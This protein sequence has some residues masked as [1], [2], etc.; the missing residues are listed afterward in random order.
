M[1]KPRNRKRS[2]DFHGKNAPGSDGPRLCATGIML[3]WGV[4]MT[5]RER[6]LN[7]CR[8]Q[9]VD[10]PPVWLMRQAGRALPEYRALRERYSFLDLVRTPELAAEVTLQPIRRFGFDAAIIFSDILVI[11]E[12]LGQAYRFRDGGGIDMAFPIRSAQD[13]PKLSWEGVA[14]RAQYV[15]DALRSTQNQLAGQTALIGFSGSPWTLANFMVEGGSAKP[16]TQALHWWREDRRTFEGFLEKLAQAV[17]EYLKGQIAAG[18]EA[19]QIFDSLSEATPIAEY[20]AISARWI[21]TIIAEL[22]GR[23]PV[24]VF[25]RGPRWPSLTASGAQVLSVDWMVSLPELRRA[26]P[27]TLAI[28]GNLNPDVLNGTLEGVTTETT[29]ILME[30]K[31]RNGFIF[32]LGHGLPPTATIENVARLVEIIRNSHG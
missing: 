31:G 7:A 28:Q 19:V 29:R 22:A 24:M 20:E 6:F 30:M 16:F 8:C 25:S 15:F 26:L 3:R 17:A 32:N 13:L 23:V 21:R 27:P 5:C 4:A 12:A 2:A 11:P 10:R 9:P 1:S 18:A 14:E